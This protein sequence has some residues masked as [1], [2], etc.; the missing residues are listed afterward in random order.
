MPAAN[1][2]VNGE[3]ELVPST[4]YTVT[5]TSGIP[6]GSITADSTSAAAE[7]TINLTI[8]PNTGYRLKTL[9]VTQTDGTSVTVN[10]SGNSRSFT[11][12]AANVT[13]NAVFELV[14][15]TTYTVT[16]TSGIP[17]GSITASPTG[18]LTAGATVNLTISPD[19]GYQLK[20]LGVT[21]TNGTA[22]PVNGSGNSRSFTMPAANVMVNGEF[23]LVP[24]TTYTVTVTSGIPNG[25]ITANPASAEA[26]TTINL[27]ISPNTGYRLKTLNVTQ[28]DG[29]VVTVNGSGNSRTFTMPAD[30]VM[31]NGEFEPVPGNYTVTVTQTANGTIAS[32]TSA[33]AG[34]TV[35]LTI[36]PNS[37]YQLKTLNVTQTDG[38]VVTVSSANNGYRFTMPA[39]NVTVSGVFESIP[40]DP[41]YAVNI[42]GGIQGGSVTTNVLKAADGTTVTLTIT[43]DDGY[44]TGMMN[45]MNMSTLAQVTPDSSSGNTV[46]FTMPAFDVT[47]GVE[48]EKLY[49]V[50]VT[51]GI[52]N[53]SI[54]AD[55]TSAARNDS[56][57]L[58]ITP[59]SGCRL[60]FITVTQMDG[61]KIGLYGSG[62]TR[63]FTMPAANVTVNAVFERL[64]T[65]TVT[66]PAHGAITA[67]P[68][69]DVEAGAVVTLNINP[70]SGYRLDTLNVTQG[71][72]A[73]TMNGSGAVRTFTMPA[74]N[75]TVSAVFTQNAPNTLAVQFVGF[76]DEFIDLSRDN[77]YDL[78]QYSDDSLTITVNGSYDEYLWYR[79]GE[80]WPRWGG[81]TY[82]V[83][84][85]DLGIHTITVVVVKNGVPYSKEVTFK[86]VRN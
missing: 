5:V 41:T 75:V 81:N 30:N 83:Y 82:T 4:T 78:R 25:S 24:V 43:P 47:V 42:M 45:I 57:I 2:T 59:D 14:P 9:S 53:G 15:S 31:V 85:L 61:A 67:N 7:A 63:S 35:T 44:R 34:A 3:F 62:N 1:V 18:N 49:A 84:G 27:T 36:N 60:K 23:E 22:V 39:A 72:T 79:D 54:T 74:A 28:T 12:P 77:Y 38:T 56:V 11:M 80:G 52:P 6:N 10:G 68:K 66:P 58:T 20:T 17:N 51:S 26:G 76:A 16:V 29:T 21:Q 8:S 48:F 32:L 73:V 46:T 71:G 86:V 50:T 55:S 33:T 19:S 13:V 37:G 64:Y 69:A 40:T 70:D 65:V